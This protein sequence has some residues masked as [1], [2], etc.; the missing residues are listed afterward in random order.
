VRSSQPHGLGLDRHRL[1]IGERPRRGERR[2][3][4]TVGIGARCSKMLRVCAPERLHGR[5]EGAA[6][7]PCR[8]ARRREQPHEIA[9]GI[10]DGAGAVEADEH[11]IVP[12]EAEETFEARE[13]GA[14]TPQQ[15]R[16][17]RRVAMVELDRRLRTQRN[18]APEA[19]F[20]RGAR[21]CAAGERAGGARD[22]RDEAAPADGLQCWCF[23]AGGVEAPAA[24]GAAS[25]ST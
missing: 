10:F 8:V 3:V 18:A 9:A 12:V 5:I 24:A 11:G 22:D 25:P 23:P 19:A 13:L 14:A 21:R 16:A 1:R 2:R 6:R 15:E 4:R 17:G 7:Q 20:E